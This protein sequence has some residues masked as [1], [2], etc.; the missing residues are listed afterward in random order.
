MKYPMCNTKHGTIVHKRPIQC[1]NLAPSF[2]KAWTQSCD[3][4]A[5]YTEQWYNNASP[6]TCTMLR[7]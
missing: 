3:T 1:Q 6:K 2:Q 7:A 4:W 5:E